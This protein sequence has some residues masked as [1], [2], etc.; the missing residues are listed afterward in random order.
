MQIL[1]LD[2]FN[3]NRKI[4]IL[5]VIIYYIL[6]I[7]YL[8]YISEEKIIKTKITKIIKTT[9]RYTF[10]IYLNKML[11]FFCITFI[12]ANN[13]TRSITIVTIS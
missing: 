3:D 9:D 4:Y 6:V 11:L 1:S 12:R 13:K 5:K 8:Y 2:I 10:T 7:P